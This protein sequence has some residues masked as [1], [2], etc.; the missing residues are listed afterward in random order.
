M[1]SHFLFESVPPTQF[2]R[3]PVPRAIA[4]SHDRGLWAQPPK[5]RDAPYVVNPSSSHSLEFDVPIPRTKVHVIHATSGQPDTRL[6]DK[7]PYD[8]VVGRK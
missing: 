3:G 4:R 5:T 1:T 2:R 7:L 6:N 8:E